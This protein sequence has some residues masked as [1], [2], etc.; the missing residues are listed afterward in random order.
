MSIELGLAIRA[1]GDTGQSTLNHDKWNR[2]LLFVRM[3][4]EYFSVW[5]FFKRELC[6]VA[7]IAERIL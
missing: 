4:N 7:K 1:I 2:L 3:S 6:C 5:E